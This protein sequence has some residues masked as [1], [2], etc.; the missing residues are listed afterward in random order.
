MV[1]LFITKEKTMAK[2]FKP[3]IEV[4]PSALG[5]VIRMLPKRKGKDMTGTASRARREIV[6]AARLAGHG[7]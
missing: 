3:K 1:I 6:K 7:V 4:L 2:I 5:S